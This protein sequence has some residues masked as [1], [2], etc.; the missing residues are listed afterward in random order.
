[1]PFAE[2]SLRPFMCSVRGSEFSSPDGKHLTAAKQQVQFSN[3]TPRPTPLLPRSVANIG[4]A[5]RRE[6]CAGS[7][8]EAPQRHLIKRFDNRVLNRTAAMNTIC[9]PLAT[10]RAVE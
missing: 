6:F 7:W 2:S 8:V 10:A 4:C 1:M 9:C 3:G 5:L